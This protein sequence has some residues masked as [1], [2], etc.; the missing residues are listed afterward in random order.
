MKMDLSIL[1]ALAEMICGDPPYDNFPYRS[2][3]YLT[4]FFRGVDLDYVHD[5]STRRWWVSNVLEELN[6]EEKS[7]PDL[8]SP[9]MIKVIEYLLNP[10]H[11][12][13]STG[14]YESAIKEVNEIL[15]IKNLIVVK[16]G[17]TN[18]V[19]L[20]KIVSGYV[21]TS[22][23]SDEAKKVITFTPSVFDVPD[24]S[25]EANLVSI[26][27]PFNLSFNNVIETV[28][29][30][31]Y[32]LNLDCKRADDIWNNSIIIQDIFE[33]IY[34]SSIVIVDFSGKNPNVFYEAGIAHTLGKHVIPITQHI[35]DVPF[36][37]RHHR[38]IIYL[39]NNQGLEELKR[40]IEERLKVL[41]EQSK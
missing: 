8:P 30:A 23:S 11:F 15:K 40:R 20:K 26:M 22:I 18:D 3:S 33:L 35:E 29:A 12:K 13:N 1:D 25:V 32:S 4:R 9:K 16:A 36:D 7:D 34:C 19:K 37:L 14:D 38:V 21:S 28:K 39:N 24:K 27:I 41:K 5:G 17:L 10:I 2:S 6:K 31:C